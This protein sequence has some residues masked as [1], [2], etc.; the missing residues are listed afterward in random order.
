VAQ[1]LPNDRTIALVTHDG[2]MDLKFIQELEI[3]IQP[4]YLLDTQKVAQHPLQLTRRI[5]LRALLNTLRIPFQHIHVAGNDA[6]FTLRALLLIGVRDL[7]SGGVQAEEEREVLV[8][9]LQ[10]VARLKRPRS[11]IKNASGPRSKK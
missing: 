8:A 3:T 1:I 7:E 11:A 2:Q 5:G 9:A 4:A 10:A 6:N